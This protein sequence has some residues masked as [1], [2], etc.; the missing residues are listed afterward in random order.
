MPSNEKALKYGSTKYESKMSEEAVEYQR[1]KK[2][3]RIELEHIR[4]IKLNGI[5]RKK[6]YPLLLGLCTHRLGVWKGEPV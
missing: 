1:K 5:G 2:Q 4:N 3:S 6:G